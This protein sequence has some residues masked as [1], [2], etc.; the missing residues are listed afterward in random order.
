MRGR[1]NEGG[2]RTSRSGEVEE[3]TCRAWRQAD[4]G[5]R[6]GERVKVRVSAGPS[7]RQLERE[8]IMLEGQ[9]CAVQMP[10]VVRERERVRKEG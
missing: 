8:R 6:A 1:V 4:A 7:R 5:K 2:L 9:L 10:R 3:W